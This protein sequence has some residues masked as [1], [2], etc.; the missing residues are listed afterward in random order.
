MK[1]PEGLVSVKEMQERLDAQHKAHQERMAKHFGEHDKLKAEYDGASKSMAQLRAEYTIKMDEL[2]SREATIRQ[3]T[4]ERDS[5]RAKV[6]ERTKADF[7]IAK[8]EFGNLS[9]QVRTLLGGEDFLKANEATPDAIMQRVEAAKKIGPIGTSP[10]VGD[11][12]KGEKP[13]MFEGLPVDGLVS[14]FTAFQKGDRGEMTR[15]ANANR[16]PYNKALDA[17]TKY[18]LSNPGKKTS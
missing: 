2:A 3:L 18:F 13:K 16:V 9:E 17:A 12:T 14:A 1:V 10:Y 4:G 8:R 6:E 11:P 7:E 15:F 5:F